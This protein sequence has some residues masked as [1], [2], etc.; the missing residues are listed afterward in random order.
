MATGAEVIT[1]AL[2]EAGVEVAF[3][4]P[5]V[6]NLPLWDAV[7]RS[8]IRLVGVRHEPTKGQAAAIR[9]QQREAEFP[10][11]DGPGAEITI[12]PAVLELAEN[13]RVRTEP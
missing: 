1:Q 4:L 6:H 12:D 7:R 11:D 2:E 13:S 3:G 5:G 8:S 10:D 9:E